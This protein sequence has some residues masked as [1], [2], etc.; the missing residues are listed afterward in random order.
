MLLAWLEDD[1][2]LQS[3]NLWSGW[4]VVR[5]LLL[6]IKQMS[7]N[8]FIL[9]LKSL[10]VFMVTVCIAKQDSLICNILCSGFSFLNKSFFE[11]FMQPLDFYLICV[12][13]PC[14]LT[15]SLIMAQEKESKRCKKKYFSLF[16]FNL[17][18][19]KCNPVG[20]LKTL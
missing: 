5:R 11:K 4:D 14:E 3:C 6:T 17:S 1:N 19:E 8:I 18:C 13:G 7:C 10:M 15:K 16:L 2:V 20:I 9:W 12:E